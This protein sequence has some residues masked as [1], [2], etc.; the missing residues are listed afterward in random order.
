MA[1]ATGEARRLRHLADEKFGPWHQLSDASGKKYTRFL[2]SISPA[3]DHDAVTDGA[4]DYVASAV[5]NLAKTV[6]SSL[7][8]LLALASY[9]R[10]VIEHKE[11]TYDQ[12]DL[13]N[14]L[15]SLSSA[16]AKISVS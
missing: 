10:T 13:R 3:G 2:D 14:L 9:A 16:A 4:A 7:P 15:L 5:Q 11:T 8:G 12:E 6:P 1:A